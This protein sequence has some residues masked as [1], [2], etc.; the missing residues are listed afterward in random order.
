MQ[1]I[2]LAICSID[3]TLPSFLVHGHVVS[4]VAV[5]AVDHVVHG[6]HVAVVALFDRH[7]V[8]M[9]M[10]VTMSCHLE[11]LPFVPPF[12]RTM[13]DRIRVESFVQ[14]LCMPLN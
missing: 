6:V 5:H 14:H 1:T 9:T 4:R 13:L 3:R 10:I 7:D 11:R 8:L 2:Q 12:R